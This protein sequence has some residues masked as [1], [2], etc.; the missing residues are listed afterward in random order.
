MVHDSINGPKPFRTLDVWLKD[1]SFKPMVKAQ[2]FGMGNVSL[3][4]KLK[5]FKDP[6]RSWNRDHFGHID[7]KIKQIEKYIDAIDC[8]GDDVVIDDTF[9]S[10]KSAL[11]SSL[12][13]WRTRKAQLYRQY[14]RVKNI[15]EKDGNTKY[16]HSITTHRMRKKFISK[17]KVNGEWFEG[18]DVVKSNIRS[19]FEHHFK[20]PAVPEITLPC[21]SFG[22]LSWE[23]YCDPTKTPR[24]DGYNLRFNLDMWDVIGNEVISFVKSFFETG[25]FPKSINTTWVTLI[26]KKESAN[27]I[28]NFRSVSM[29]GCFYKIISKI[30][31]GRI[32]PLMNSIISEN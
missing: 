32:K 21:N 7:S 22:K 20:Q 10:R 23:V 3:P 13:L 11:E 24:Y 19:Y 27:A 30:L 9:M 5:G 1:P 15:A 17:L 18:G 28:E 14:S 29:V 12:H 25:C 8:Q 6:I 26:P 2:W 31:A 16:F 4:T